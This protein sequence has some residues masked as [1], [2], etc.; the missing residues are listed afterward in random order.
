MPYQSDWMLLD[1]DKMRS[2]AMGKVLLRLYG[3][4]G[5]QYIA[6]RYLCVVCSNRYVVCKNQYVVCSNLRVV[7]SSQYAVC[8]SQYAAYNNL[9]VVYG[10]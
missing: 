1:F 7:Y 5:E 10:K 6:Y 2:K 4:C 8:G 3:V 9:R